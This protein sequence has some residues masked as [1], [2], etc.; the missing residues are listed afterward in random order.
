[1][2]MSSSS[3]NKVSLTYRDSGVHLAA[4]DRAVDAFKP[5]AAKTHRPGVME[6]LGGFGALFSLGA[7]GFGPTGD[8]DTVLVSATDGV[9]TKL[10]LAFELNRHDTIGI[11]CVAMCVNDVLT[12]G[13]QPLFFLDYIATGKLSEQQVVAVVS[14]IADG[15]ATSRCALL[16]GETAEMPGFYNAGEYDVAGFCV[17]A[18][19]RSDLWRPDAVQPGDR[20]LGLASTGLHSNGFSLA[21]AIITR[22]GLDLHATYPALGASATLGELLLTPTALYGAA[23]GAMRQAA[24]VFGAAHITGGGILENLPRI[25]PPGLGAHITRAAW[26]VPPIF[27]FLATHGGVAQAE[28]DR[29][30][31]MG[32][33]LVVIVRGDAAPAIAAA[34]AAGIEAWEI[35]AVVSGEGVVV[36]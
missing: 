21:R 27:P 22:A 12:T 30:W 5:L 11:D 20:L 4:P 7:A 24:Q 34:K 36:L 31:N 19:R 8:D 26:P 13:A 35:G 25:L 16:G 6:G 2:H 29:V 28:Q 10:K 3:D 14:G 18:A 15:C 33:G 32:V 17:G 9:G 23:L 1:M